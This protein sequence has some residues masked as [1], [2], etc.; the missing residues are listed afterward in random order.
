MYRSICWRRNSSSG[1]RS[2]WPGWLDLLAAELLERGTI[3][4][5]GLAPVH[6]PAV[7]DRQ[8]GPSV[9]QCDRQV[10]GLRAD[11]DRRPVS[12]HRHHLLVAEP[13]VLDRIVL[14]G[15][16]QHR[17]LAGEQRPLGHARRAVGRS[18]RTEG[19]DRKH[20]RAACGGQR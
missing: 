8:P 20:Q 13:Q 15:G 19:G 2:V 9:S 16:N 7:D 4:L 18:D 1:G 6:A 17:L 12:G 5:A 3:G 11:L 10:D 14:A